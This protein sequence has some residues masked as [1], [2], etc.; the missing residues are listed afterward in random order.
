MKVIGWDHEKEG[1]AEG[2]DNGI[3]GLVSREAKD[4]DDDDED[5][6]RIS[7]NKSAPR[8]VAGGH[9]NLHGNYRGKRKK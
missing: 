5:R 8:F 4:D 3:G 7:C 6:V 1:E 2:E 9:N